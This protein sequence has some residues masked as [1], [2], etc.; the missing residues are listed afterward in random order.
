MATALAKPTG[1]SLPLGR[2]ASPEEY[3]GLYVLL[4]SDESSAIMTGT[5]LDADGGI[6]LWGPGRRTP[7]TP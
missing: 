6:S 3:A 4:A 1:Q 5:I 7:S 2:I